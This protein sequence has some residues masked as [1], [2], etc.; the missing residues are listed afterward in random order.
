MQQ[1][2][3]IKGESGDGKQQHFGL[4]APQDIFIFT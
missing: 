2:E 4:I 1:T 3:R